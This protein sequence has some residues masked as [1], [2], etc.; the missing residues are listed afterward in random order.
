MEQPNTTYIQQISGG[1]LAFE[2]KL[3]SIVKQE[4]VQ[5]RARYEEAMGAQ[6]YSEAAEVVHKI[7]HK[8]SILGL[9]KG[10]VLSGQFEAAL[11]SGKDLT[12]QTAF[13]EL[14]DLID[15]YLVSL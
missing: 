12:L 5:E 6:H 9:E 14:L 1:D 11:K 10:F 4:F 13:A 3:I 2:A 7:R 15:S 8:I